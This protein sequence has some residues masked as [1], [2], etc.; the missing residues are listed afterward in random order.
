MRRKG[1]LYLHRAK[2]PF[3]H[4]DL[5]E[6]DLFL[7]VELRNQSL[8][9]ARGNEIPFFFAPQFFIGCRHEDFYPLLMDICCPCIF[10]DKRLWIRLLYP[11]R[12][13][14]THKIAL[15]VFCALNSQIYTSFI[16]GHLLKICGK[17]VEICGKY[18]AKH[19]T[20]KEFDKFTVIS[21]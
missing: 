20:N 4:G 8:M 1:I 14:R 6:F 11:Q 13:L 17:Y 21:W 18:V 19:Y 3:F 7:A 12:W 2:T 5:Q 10:Y 16:T 15:R 9:R